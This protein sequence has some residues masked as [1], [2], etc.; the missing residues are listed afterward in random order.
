MRYLTLI[1]FILCLG[2]KANAQIEPPTLNCIEG[3]GTTL[4]ISWSPP[5]TF[6]GLIT[7]YEVF[8]SGSENGPYTSF[9]IDDPLVFDT[10][11]NS[12]DQI[13]YCFMQ[14]QMDCPGEP[15]L[16]SDT[17]IWNLAPPVMQSVSV[18]DDGQIV[19]TWLPDESPDVA[20]YLIYVDGADP[21]D[22]VYG[23]QSNTYVDSV[24]DPSTSVHE[25]KLA[26]WKD[27][28]NDMDRRGS[29]GLPYESILAQNLQQDRCARSFNFSWSRYENYN[30]GVIGYEVEVSEN[31]GSFQPVDTVGNVSQIYNFTNAITD[32]FYC[33]RVN[34]LLPNGIKASSNQ[35]C[36]TARV[37]DSPVGGHIRNATVIDDL[38]VQVEFYP[39]T[40]GVLDLIFAERKV[41]GNNFRDWP[42]SLQGSAG[43]PSYDVYWDVNAE[44]QRQDYAYRFVR[45]DECA[46]Q[47]TSDTVKTILLD[48]GIGSGLSG[49]LEWTAYENSRGNVVGYDVI[50]TVNGFSTTLA[51]LTS[52][53]FEYTEEAALDGTSLDTVCYTIIAEIELDIESI[54]GSVNETIFS[55]SNEVCLNP[56]PRV[57]FPTAFRPEGF[58]IIFKPIIRFGTP[59]GYEFRIYDRYQRLLFQTN[60][61]NEG[62]DGTDNGEIAPMNNYVYYLIFTGQDGEQY[63]DTGNVILLR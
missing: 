33:F 40:A 38:T 6:C 21:P 48:A 36:D 31:G 41:G 39:D 26:W 32:V 49:E 35:V 28:V 53:E 22:T 17:L 59:A 62:W 2:W 52:N 55:S 27:C 11:F 43:S 9:T 37:V 61:I 14:S 24:S 20:A 47:F 42:V 10:I 54:P 50:K 16:N 3:N 18:N 5:T 30:D 29:I 60:D 57:I 25:Y 7:G 58:N 56:R 46:N 12:A 44:T 45:E 34:A 15:A 23:N 13:V 19:V 4:E 8:Y 1:L 63:T 51:S